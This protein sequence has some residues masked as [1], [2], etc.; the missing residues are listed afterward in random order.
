VDVPHGLPAE[1]LI[2]Y[3]RGALKGREMRQ[4]NK[5]LGL[6]ILLN[7]APAAAAQPSPHAEVREQ[8]QSVT[9]TGERAQSEAERRREASR[10]FDSHAVRTRTRIGQLAR[11]HRPIC[12]RTGG[13]P[14][15]LGARIATRIMD[16]AEGV[17]VPV[18]RAELCAPNVRIGFTNEPQ[19]MV[20]RAAR[21][22]RLVIGFH[23]AARRDA[24]MRVRQ[25]VQA[26]YTTT[27]R[28][29]PGSASTDEASDAESIDQAGVRTPG[30]SA[31]SRLGNG[32]S[33]GLAH[34]MIFADTR[35]V[36]G[37]DADA[38]AE[39]LAYLA[40]AQTP[41]AEVCDAA[42]TILNLMNPAC[43]PSRRPTSLTPQ[44]IAYLRALYSVDPTWGPQLQR[45]TVVL[46]MANRL[47]DGR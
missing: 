1:D 39:L 41:V 30:G 46:N 34:V 10:F 25:P 16:I 47:G 26:W 19:A 6:C 35:I 38:M 31:G 5:L 14:P 45:G 36:A 13:L 32:L 18:N 21:R 9:V 43:P 17:G 42:D 8:G 28:A 2:G 3:G 24:V 7:L 37:E 22:N 11:W 15:E 4:P 33:S 20:E 40:L 27:T 44:D 29:G 23:Y 12:V